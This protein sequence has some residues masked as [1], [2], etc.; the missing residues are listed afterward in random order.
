VPPLILKNVTSPGGNE[1][2]YLKVAKLA[3]YHRVA[4]YPKPNLLAAALITRSGEF[5]IASSAMDGWA[6]AYHTDLLDLK[7]DQD[8]GF[9][10]VGFSEKRALALDRRGN[11]LVMELKLR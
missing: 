8:G 10:S 1:R 9:C 6:L 4:C 3:E 5:L 2:V 7:L 11:L